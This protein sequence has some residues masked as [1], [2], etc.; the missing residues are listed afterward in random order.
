MAT[1]TT[2]ASAGTGYTIP[3]SG[4]SSASSGGRADSQTTTGAAYSTVALRSF[5]VSSQLNTGSSVGAVNIGHTVFIAEF[6]PAP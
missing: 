3:A 6:A 4:G 1:G 5:V 2:L